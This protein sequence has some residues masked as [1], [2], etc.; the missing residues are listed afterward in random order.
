MVSR[1][2]RQE[3]MG[4]ADIMSIDNF[5]MQFA[6]IPFSKADP[7]KSLSL[8]V[9]GASIPGT[10]NEAFAVRLGGYTR[11]FRGRQDFSHRLD[12]TFA[13]PSDLVTMDSLRD[14]HEGTAGSASGTSKGYQADYS[15]T[16][17]LYIYDTAGKVVDVA[18][19]HRLFITALNDVAMDST[20]S[21]AMYVTASFSYDFVTW[22][23]T[24]SR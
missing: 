13:V 21:G 14:W 15:T 11:L 10:H 16:G 5:V 18:T 7:Y 9:Q 3:A 23:S 22:Q 2:A 8:Q 1:I 4:V 19:F 20:R 17:D 6:S 24:E 12:L